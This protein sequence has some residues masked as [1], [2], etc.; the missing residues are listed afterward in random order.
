MR[1]GTKN[2]RKWLYVD[3]EKILRKLIE[4][5]AEQERVNVKV[6]LEKRWKQMKRKLDKNKVGMFIATV[7]TT[8]LV[9]NKIVQAGT[10]FCLST[11][12]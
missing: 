10:I 6:E 12:Y 8:T 9:I 3:Y 5:C 11:I 7:I 1:H 2:E 4:I